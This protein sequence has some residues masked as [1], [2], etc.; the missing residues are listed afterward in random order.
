M[1]R[2]IFNYSVLQNGKLHYVRADFFRLENNHVVFYLMSNETTYTI[3]MYKDVEAVW[4]TPIEAEKTAP[5][6]DI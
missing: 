3:A 5:T 2:P 4:F 1:Q 6:D